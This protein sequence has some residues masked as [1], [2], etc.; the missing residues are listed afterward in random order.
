MVEAVSLIALG[1]GYTV[2]VNA[3]KEKKNVKFLGQ[4]IGI[5]IMIA[6]V[7]TMVCDSMKSAYKYG[8][9]FSSKSRCQKMDKAMC[10][11]MK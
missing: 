4:G 9:P 8:C 2:L 1:V 7:L 10:P 11:F 5:L 6:S 3:S